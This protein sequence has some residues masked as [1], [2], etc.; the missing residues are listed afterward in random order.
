MNMMELQ[1]REMHAE[2]DHKASKLCR[3]YENIVEKCL[4]KNNL[5]TCGNKMADLRRC[6][7]TQKKKICDAI[8]FEYGGDYQ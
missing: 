2:L 8:G 5:V 6:L 4:Q 7:N 1:K 3:K